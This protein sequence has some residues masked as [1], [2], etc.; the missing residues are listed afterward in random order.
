MLVMAKVQKKTYDLG[1]CE[2]LELQWRW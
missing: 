1:G 2:V